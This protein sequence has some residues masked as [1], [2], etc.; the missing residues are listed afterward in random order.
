[1]CMYTNVY[2]NDVCEM[3]AVLSVAGGDELMIFA[4]TALEN[5]QIF[6]DVS[7][8]CGKFISS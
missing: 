7:F 2:K 6:R 5:F 3:A 1:M 4:S 8:R